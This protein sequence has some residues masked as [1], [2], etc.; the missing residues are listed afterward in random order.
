MSIFSAVRKK[1][2][3]STRDQINVME[4]YLEGHTIQAIS[5]KTRDITGEFSLSGSRPSWNWEIMDYCIKKKVKST[6][7]FEKIE[8]MLA[9]LA[10]KSILCIERE[11]KTQLGYHVRS[12]NSEL[13]WDWAH[14]DYEVKESD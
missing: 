8:V 4:A 3:Q 12:N 2:A 1:M 10:G 6:T 13:L 11:T 5:R 9:F 14:F 7:T